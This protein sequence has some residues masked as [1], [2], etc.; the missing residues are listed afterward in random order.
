METVMKTEFE[1]KVKEFDNKETELI[2]MLNNLGECVSYFGFI[3]TP[4][5]LA[6][7]K[8]RLND[9]EVQDVQT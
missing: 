3:L 2:V 1:F 5:Q 4:E 7:L 9:P 6:D 8:E